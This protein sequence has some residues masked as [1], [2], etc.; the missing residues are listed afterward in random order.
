MD[1]TA[2]VWHNGQTITVSKTMDFDEV[3]AAFRDAQ[4]NYIPEDAVFTLTDRGRAHLEELKE[5][6]RDRMGADLCE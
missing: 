6:Q 1:I 3:R 2:K 5:R 4:E